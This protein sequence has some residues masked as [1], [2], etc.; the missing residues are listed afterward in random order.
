M[1]KVYR[2]KKYKQGK[3]VID[4]ILS[5]IGGMHSITFALLSIHGRKKQTASPLLSILFNEMPGHLIHIG[6]PKAGSTFLQEW[7]RQNPQLFYSPGGLGGFNNVYEISRQASQKAGE[8]F[9]YFVTSDESL[10]T[11]KSSSGALP[12]DDGK[13]NFALPLPA[14][15][16]QQ[17]VCGMLKCLYPNGKILFVTRGFK[18]IMMSGFSQ[19]IRAGG[20]LRFQEFANENRLAMQ[21]KTTEIKYGEE[22][23]YTFIAG[24][25]EEAFGQ[26]NVIIL[27]FELLRDD[28]NKFITIIEERLGLSKFNTQTG[29]INE[30]LSP[31]ELYWY[32]RISSVV[33]RISQRFGQKFY[34]K[35]YRWYV[36]KTLKNKF[37]AVIKI[38]SRLK[39][40]RR[41]TEADFPA[42]L[43]DYFRENNAERFAAKFR[44]NPIYAPYRS[45]YLLD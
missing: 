20:V 10:S 24:I 45:E 2:K 3:T 42:E 36:G 12:V 30:S 31:E 23:N 16:A 28:Q 6:Y 38:L 4:Q 14:K 7:F 19:Y 26:E 15:A 9:N 39:P 17:K 40:N 43:L 34:T 44:N 5:R 25:Y 33:S 21:D 18:G 22:V 13:R 32:P 27:P 1:P 35:V 8:E 29:K 11:P 37:R 41:V